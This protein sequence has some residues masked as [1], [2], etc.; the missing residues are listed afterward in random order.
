MPWIGELPLK[1]VEW[2]QHQ[3]HVA[4]VHQTDLV[5]VD[6]WKPELGTELNVSSN[7]RHFELPGLSTF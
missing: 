7:D 2:S 6:F 3:L 1:V 4:E 5:S